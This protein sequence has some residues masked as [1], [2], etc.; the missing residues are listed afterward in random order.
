MKYIDSFTLFLNESEINVDG[1]SP[2]QF[3][4][5]RYARK[6][7][8]K[9]YTGK[10]IK[11]K[12]DLYITREGI[13]KYAD[14][15]LKAISYNS[16]QDPHPYI[17]VEIQGKTYL[18]CLYRAVA[19]TWGG[20]KDFY[21]NKKERKKIGDVETV[22]YIDYAY[23]LIDPYLGII[24]SNIKRISRNDLRQKGNRKYIEKVN[25]QKKLGVYYKS[26][27]IN[28]Y[29]LTEN[30]LEEIVSRYKKGETLLSIFTAYKIPKDSLV[31]YL[32]DLKLF[33]DTS[34]TKTLSS[35]DFLNNL[36]QYKTLAALGKIYNTSAM[37][38]KRRL[39][40]EIQNG[41]FTREE[42]E[43]LQKTR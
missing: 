10:L 13:V 21:F 18:M 26:I 34:K 41:N 11:L 38:I 9:S 40:K 1:N 15:K 20:Y 17:S 5:L 14:G 31:N 4:D 42:W 33:K 25:F 27:L 12:K 19:E 35:D 30:D 3:D 39:E 24:P 37:S 29:N 2:I 16:S 43:E 8:F 22:G 6:I 32:K 7:T 23:D 36:R 28:D